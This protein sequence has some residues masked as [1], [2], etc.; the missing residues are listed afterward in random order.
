M[1]PISKYKK[2]IRYKMEVR[3]LGLIQYLILA[4]YFSLFRNF[5]SCTFL[6]VL[7]LFFSLSLLLYI[8]DIT[9]HISTEYSFAYIFIKICT[10]RFILDSLAF[11]LAIY[12]LYYRFNLFRACKFRR[13]SCSGYPSSKSCAAINLVV[14]TLQLCCLVFKEC[15]T[16]CPN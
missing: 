7:F 9:T 8:F 4:F 12:R 11:F 14:I 16:R 10:Y 2:D 15:T 1:L 3:G 13:F 6:F 5:F